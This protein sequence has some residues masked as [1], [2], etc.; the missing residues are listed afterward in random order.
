[1]SK[2]LLDRSVEACR[3]AIARTI[4]YPSKYVIS[5]RM[6]TNINNIN[7]REKSYENIIISLRH[8]FTIQ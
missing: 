3:S 5:N 7:E 4:S 2:E 6:W 1:M 8:R